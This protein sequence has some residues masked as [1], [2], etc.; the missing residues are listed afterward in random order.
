MFRD[1]YAIGIHPEELLE[2]EYWQY[3]ACAEGYQEKLR[4]YGIQNVY[5][6]FWT[7]YFSNAKK[8]RSPKEIIRK[9]YTKTPKQKTKPVDI[10][11]EELERQEAEFMAKF[12][13]EVT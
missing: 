3:A 6:S 5:Q 1:A 11:V 10:N 8:G 7:A 2:M 9:Y 4:A 12:S 13:K